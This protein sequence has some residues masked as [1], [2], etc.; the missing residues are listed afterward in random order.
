M[1]AL[2]T[3]RGFFHAAIKGNPAMPSGRLMPALNAKRTR[4]RQGPVGTSGA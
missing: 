2:Q 1:P 3:G 4:D